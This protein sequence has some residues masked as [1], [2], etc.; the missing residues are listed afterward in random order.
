MQTKQKVP[1]IPRLIKGQVSSKH[2]NIR[3]ASKVLKYVQV[4]RGNQGHRG[5]KFIRQSK[6]P[7]KDLGQGC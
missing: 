5:L 4:G 2:L 1:L 3:K 7:T 6:I